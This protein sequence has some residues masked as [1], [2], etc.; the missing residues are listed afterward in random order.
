MPLTFDRF[1]EVVLHEEVNKITK[2]LSTRRH[3]IHSP[4][5]AMTSHNILKKKGY[6]RKFTTVK[7]KKDGV[8]HYVHH[9]VGP[10]GDVK[11]IEVDG[12]F[13]PEK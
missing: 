7:S 6:K 12:Y 3:W 11:S 13:H 10:K 9:Y 8:S 2:V 5:Q 1:V 4:K